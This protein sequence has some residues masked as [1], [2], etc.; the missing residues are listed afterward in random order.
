M[1]DSYIPRS[2]ND[3]RAWLDNFVNV[4]STH[5]STLGLTSAQITQ[6]TNNNSNWINALQDLLSYKNLTKGATLTK[7]NARK[8]AE[9]YVRQLVR[10]I[11]VRPGVS[12]QLK[13][14]LGI[15]VHDTEPTPIIPITPANLVAQGF[16]TGVNQLKW[17]ANGN[18]KGTQYVIEAR[19]NDSSEWVLVDV[20]LKTRYSHQNQTPGVRV[21]YRV[22]A[23]RTEFVSSP[24]NVAVV[25]GNGE[26]LTLSEAA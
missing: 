21:F 9:S 19:Y 7:I 18:K 12:D 4:A 1:S 20:I 26:F 25:Y 13:K 2:D 8:T 5:S 3:F 11:Q 23:K 6:L 16:E 10:N 22:R 14:E 24:S 15:T 17:S